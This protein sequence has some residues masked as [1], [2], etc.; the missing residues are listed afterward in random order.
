MDGSNRRVIFPNASCK[1]RTFHYVVFPTL[2]YHSL[3]HFLPIHVD[4]DALCSVVRRQPVLGVLVVEGPRRDDDEE[5]EGGA[6]E[7]NV[8]CELDV[9]LREANEESN[10]LG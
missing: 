5:G 8:E 2:F 4:T 10:N 1:C 3:T 9:L 7:A 6:G